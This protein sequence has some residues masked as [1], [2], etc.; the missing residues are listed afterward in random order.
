[1]ARCRPTASETI[2]S[3]SGRSFI[4]ER[5][6]EIAEHAPLYGYGFRSG[7]AQSYLWVAHAH[8]AFLEAYIGLGILGLFFVVATLL[9]ALRRALQLI[10]DR[11]CVPISRD[12][13]LEY[14]ALLVPIV[15]FSVSEAGLAAG[16]GFSQLIF[17]AIFARFE[18][19]WQTL[20]QR[21]SVSVYQQVMQEQE[22][23]IPGRRLS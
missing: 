4:Y 9:S 8:D 11:S 22:A 21:S 7:R 12:L 5:A 19:A 10:T 18:V 23:R 1:M 3:F 2:E 6:L 16:V 13:G 20:R 15:A 17:L 14:L